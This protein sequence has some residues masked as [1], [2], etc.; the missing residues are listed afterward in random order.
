[1]KPVFSIC[2]VLYGDHLDLA[3]RLLDS[4]RDVHYVQDIR[5]GLN[6]VHS[7]T[8]DYV[9]RWAAEQKRQRPVYLYQP[10]EGLNAG[11]YPLMRQMFR[12]REI[13]KR[14][15]W[16]DDDSYLDEQVGKP[17]WDQAM[18]LSR[19]FRQIGS[20]HSIMGRGRQHEV[21]AQQ[22]WFRNKPFNARSRFKFITGGWWIAQTEFLR[23][24]DYPFPDLYHNGGD[25]ILGEL[26]RQQDEPLG[27]LTGGMQCHCEDCMRKRSAR[28]APVVH[29]NVGGRKGRRGL[30]VHDE[31]Y[32][33]ADGNS[34]PLL[35][36]Q[37]FSLSIY[38]YEI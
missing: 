14:I 23:K 20:I 32:I 30:G 36:H 22:P 18:E 7:R 34:Q 4:L 35:D 24:W 26:L 6:A 21:I 31:R 10:T 16:F 8:Q 19:N 25:S 1:M 33:W 17:W 27:K 37:N 2:A 29:I 12:D 38:R 9:H 11:K 3:T 13:A 5:L 28:S 15:M